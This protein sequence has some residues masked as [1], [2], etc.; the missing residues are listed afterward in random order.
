M[1]NKTQAKAAIDAAALAAKAEIDNIPPVGVNIVD[2]QI[3]FAPTRYIFKLNAGGVEATAVSW[4]NSIKANLEAAAR[5]Y[6]VSANMGR[7]QLDVSNDRIII[8]TSD[9]STFIITNF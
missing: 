3:T 2:G 1:A 5:T 9:A 8:I 6:T 7:R 4:L